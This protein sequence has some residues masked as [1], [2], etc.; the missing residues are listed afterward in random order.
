VACVE[1][2]Q[3]RESRTAISS[4][5]LITYLHPNSGLATRPSLHIITRG[6]GILRTILDDRPAPQATVNNQYFYSATIHDT[7]RHGVV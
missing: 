1:L 6:L 7:S 4:P 5:T 2:P 3:L